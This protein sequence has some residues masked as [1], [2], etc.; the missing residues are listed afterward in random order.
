MVI[1]GTKTVGILGSTGFLGKHVFA[2]FTENSW[3]VVGG[4][5]R[6]NVDA[7]NL[8]SVINWI[9][10]NDIKYLINLAAY[11]GGIGLNQAKP[12]SLWLETTRIMTT[13]FEAARLTNLTKLVQIGTVCSYAKDCHVPFK[14]DYL[15]H[16]GEPEPT[17]RAYGMAK[18]NGLYG[19]Q[20]YRH[21]YGI[22]IIYLIPVNLYG[23][24]DNFD[25]K[26]SHVIPAMIKKCIEAKMKSNSEVIL[27]GDG[28]P[29]REFL[30]AKD[31]ARAILLATM[32]Y[33]GAEPVNIGTGVELTM[34]EL[35]Q[36]IKEETGYRG[37]IV[38]DPS[39]PNGQ[40]RRCLDISRAKDYFGFEAA[41]NLRDGI[42]GTVA[43]YLSTYYGL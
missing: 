36:M 2:C 26:T 33:D 3:T 11:C 25:L 6:T 12:A 43:W 13:I 10:N 15:M 32:Q 24:Y 16:F 34:A 40:P 19:C 42:R 37:N 31:C 28:T 5:R 7:T 22:N 4:S 41:I 27:W 20:A 21:E 39:K 29:T 17:N 14:E 23:E 8:Q 38:W 18:L 30:H 1:P 9:T 35:A